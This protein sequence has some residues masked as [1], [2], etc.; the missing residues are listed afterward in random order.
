MNPAKNGNAKNNIMRGPQGEQGPPGPRG[1]PGQRG[2]PG[3]PGD[4]GSPGTGV[5][6]LGT[7]PLV[8]GKTYNPGDLI[9]VPETGIV[10]ICIQQNTNGP[11]GKL[12]SEAAKPYWQLYSRGGVN[13]ASVNFVG[14]YSPDVSYNYYDTVNDTSGHYFLSIWNKENDA[15]LGYNIRQPLPKY[16]ISGNYSLVDNFGN[17]ILDAANKLQPSLYWKFYTRDGYTTNFTGEYSLTKPYSYYDLAT[18]TDASGRKTTY[19]SMVKGSKSNTGNDP[20]TMG[21]NY[22]TIYSQDGQNGTSIQYKGIWSINTVYS[23]NDV[24]KDTSDNSYISNK[25]NNKGN[26]LPSFNATSYVFDVSN[27]YWDLLTKAGSTFNQRGKWYSDVC[28]NLYDV[29]SDNSGSTFISKWDNVIGDVNRGKPLPTY[30]YATNTYADTKYWHFLV[31]NGYSITST[32]YWSP[33]REYFEGNLAK[34]IGDNSINIVY[35]SIWKPGSGIKNL[36]RHP[37]TD[38]SAS[39]FWSEYSRDGQNGANGLGYKNRGTWSPDLSY[40]VQDVIYYN[41]STYSCA[42]GNINKVPPENS[43]YWYTFFDGFHSRGDWSNNNLLG[44][45]CYNTFDTVTFRNTQFTCASFNK[46]KTTPNSQ[47]NPGYDTTYWK[48]YIQGTYY[49][50][51]WISGG[52]YYYNDIT[53]FKGTSYQCASGITSSQDPP[54]LGS[55][56]WNSTTQGFHNKGTWDPSTV[57]HINDVVSWKNSIYTCASNN[58]S[59]IAIMPSST[60]TVPKFWTVFSE[61]YN[62]RGFWNNGNTW[63]TPTTGPTGISYDLF[64][65][66]LFHNTQFT[67]ASY[68]NSNDPKTTPNPGFHT[69][70]WEVYIPNV[71]YINAEWSPNTRYYFNDSITYK[72]TSYLCIS[73]TPISNNGSPDVSS[74]YWF[75]TTQGVQFKGAWASNNYYG[76]QDMVTVN[77]SFYTCISGNT[78]TP[79]NKPPNTT[80]WYQLIASNN[81][82]GDWSANS[83]TTDFS[84]SVYD[85]VTFRNTQFV[86]VSANTV[87]NTNYSQVQPNPGYDTSYWKRYINATYYAGQWTSGKTYYYN[88]IAVFKGSSYQCVSGNTSSLNPLEAGSTYWTST[89]A[90]FHNRGQWNA[91]VTYYLNDVVSHKNS[92]YCCASSNILNIEPNSAV[93]VPDYWTVFSEGYNDRRSWNNGNWTVPINY[94]T[95]ISYDLF[96]QVLFRNTKF[97]CVTPHTTG[98]DITVP[99][100]GFDTDYW[101]L[102]IAG[103]YYI[104]APWSASTRYYFKDVIT[105]N[106]SRYSCISGTP[107]GAIINGSPDVSSNYWFK[108]SQG[109][110]LRGTWASNNYYGVQDMVTVNNSFYS[111]ISGNTATTS[112]KP[113]NST[114]WTPLSISTNIRGDWSANNVKVDVSYSAYDQVTFRNTQFLCISANTVTNN[115]YSQVQPNPGYDTPYWRIYGNRGTYYAGQ[116]ASGG[117]YYYNDIAV[118]RSTSYQC[119]SGITSHKDPPTLGTSYWES[120]IQ[121][122]ENKGEWKS[123]EVYHINDVVSYKN[124]VY[125][126]ASNNVSGQAT[127]PSSTLTVPDY[128]TVFSEGYYNRG[129]WNDGSWSLPVSRPGVS[130][131]LFDLVTFRGSQFTCISYNNSFNTATVPN[132]GFNTLYWDV[133]NGQKTYNVPGNWTQGSRYYYNDIVTNADSRFPLGKWQCISGNYS[134][135]ITLS[136]NTYWTATGTQGVDGQDGINSKGTFLKGVKYNEKDIVQFHGSTFEC[137]S[138]ITQS[139]DYSYNKTVYPSNDLSN[140]QP[141]PGLNTPYWK[142]TILSSSYFVGTWTASGTYYQNDVVSLNQYNPYTFTCISFNSGYYPPLVNSSAYWSKYETNGNPSATSHEWTTGISYEI[143]HQVTFH[144]ATFQC[145]SNITQSIPY[146]KNGSISPNADTLNNQPIPGINT[147]YWVNISKAISYSAGTWSSNTTYYENDVVSLGPNSQYTFTCL[148]FNTG[149]YPPSPLLNP[150]TTN[151][152]QPTPL[153]KA[154]STWSPISNYTYSDRYYTY[155]DVVVLPSTIYSNIGVTFQCISNITQIVPY[156]GTNISTTTQPIPGPQYFNTSFWNVLPATAPSTPIFSASG[157]IWNKDVIYYYYDKV[158]LGPNNPT[159]YRCETSNKG[160]YPPTASASYWTIINSPSIPVRPW[161]AG[162]SF[163]FGSLTTFNGNTFQCISNITQSQSIAYNPQ[164][165]PTDSRNTQPIPGVDTLY[166]NYSKSPAIKASSPN[167]MSG[168]YSPTQTYYYNDLVTLGPYS[169]STYVCASLNSYN[170]S[171][172]P[173][174]NIGTYWNSPTVIQGPTRTWA[175]GISYQ[176]YDYVSFH[177]TVFTCLSYISQSANYSNYSA[178]IPPELDTLN[179]QPIPGPN[180]YKTPYWKVQSSTT[181]PTGINWTAGGN[182]YYNDIVTNTLPTYSLGSWLCISGNY[183]NS[184]ITLN[185]NV[186][187]KGTGTNGTNGTNGSEGDNGLNGLILIDFTKDFNY[188]PYIDIN[189]QLNLSNMTLSDLIVNDSGSVQLIV[190]NN[191]APNNNYGQLLNSSSILYSIDYGVNWNIFAIF[192]PVILTSIRV[193]SSQKYQ[194]VIGFENMDGTQSP[195]GNKIVL[196]TSNNYGASW[197]NNIKYKDRTVYNYIKNVQKLPPISEYVGIGLSYVTTVDASINQ[198]IIYLNNT[199]N[200]VPKM[201]IFGNGISNIV[202][203][204]NSTL[205]YITVYNNITQVIPSG[206]ILLFNPIQTNSNITN[207]PKTIFVNSV[208]KLCCYMG[209]TGSNIPSN[210]YI[211]SIDDL[212]NYITINNK[213]LGNI[214]FSSVIP[215]DVNLPMLT[216]SKGVTKNVVPPSS[217]VN[218]KCTSFVS[219]PTTTYISN[220]NGTTTTITPPLNI[221]TLTNYEKNIY[222]VNPGT[223]IYIAGYTFTICMVDY[224]ANTIAVLPLYSHFDSTNVPITTSLGNINVLNVFTTNYSIATS[225]G[226]TILTNNTDNGGNLLPYAYIDKNTIHPK[227]YTGSPQTLVA[228][229]INDGSFNTLKILNSTN[230][231]TTQPLQQYSNLIIPLTDIGSISIGMYV[232]S[233]NNITIQPDNNGTTYPLI[234]TGIGYFSGTATLV[235]GALSGSNQLVMNKI[236]IFNSNDTTTGINSFLNYFYTTNSFIPYLN[237]MIVS[238]NSTINF[239]DNTYITSITYNNSLSNF[240][241]VTITISQPIQNDLPSN[242]T[243]SFM[244]NFITC[245]NNGTNLTP[246]TNPIPPDI[247]FS[248]SYNKTFTSSNNSLIS[249]NITITDLDNI[250]I[251]MNVE[252]TNIPQ[253]SYITNISSS[254]FSGVSYYD[255]SNNISSDIINYTALSPIHNSVFSINTLNGITLGTCVYSSTSD[256]A[257]SLTTSNYF[258]VA[259]NPIVSYPLVKDSLINTNKLYFS[260]VD[261]SFIIPN[262]TKIIHENISSGTVVKQISYINGLYCITINSSIISSISNLTYIS[263]QVNLLT[264]VDKN[265]TYTYDTNGCPTNTVSDSKWGNSGN[266][267]TFI[268]SNS[269]NT[270]TISQNSSIPSYLPPFTRLDYTNTNVWYGSMLTLSSTQNLYTNMLAV[271]ENIAD[272][273]CILN[274]LNNTVSLSKPVMN[275]LPIGSVIKFYPVSK[276]TYTQSRFTQAIMLTSSPNGE[277]STGDIIFGTGSGIRPNTFVM[278]NGIETIQNATEYPINISVVNGFSG[279]ANKTL[280]YKLLK[281]TT[282]MQTDFGNTL[283]LNITTSIDKD[284]NKITVVFPGMT[285][286]GTNIPYNTKILSVNTINNTIVISNNINQPVPLNTALDIYFEYTTTSNVFSGTTM[287]MPQGQSVFGLSTGMTLAGSGM[288]PNINIVNI[289]TSN[290]WITLSDIINYDSYVPDLWPFGQVFP[291]IEGPDMDRAGGNPTGNLLNPGGYHS[292]PWNIVHIYSYLIYNTV[293]ILANTSYVIVNNLNGIKEGMT[294]VLLYDTGINTGKI[295]DKSGGP[296][297]FGSFTNYFPSNITVTNISYTNN[298]IYLSSPI[299]FPSNYTNSSIN[300]FL[301]F[302]TP[303]IKTIASISA[304]NL[305]T[306]CLNTTSNLMIGMQITSSSNTTFSGIISNI[307]FTTNIITLQT[308]L[309]GKIDVG[310]ILYSSTNK[311]SI[312]DNKLYS[313]NTY[314]T[315][316]TSI[317]TDISVIPINSI[318]NLRTGMIVSGSNIPQ[319][320]VVTSIN[321]SSTSSS[322]QITNLIHTLP[323]STYL[324]FTLN[325]I[326]ISQNI[327]SIISAGTSLQFLNTTTT[328]PVIYDDGNQTLGDISNNVYSI[329]MSSDG[330]FQTFVSGY[331]DASISTVYPGVL[332]YCSSGNTQSPYP[333]WNNISISPA[334]AFNKVA[335]SSNGQYQTAVGYNNNGTIFVS[336][337]YGSTWTPIQLITSNTLAYVN[338]RFINATSFTNTNF[339]DVT[340]NSTGKYQYI[341]GY[342]KSNSLGGFTINNSNYNGIIFSSN[343]FGS[344][345]SWSQAP[346]NTIDTNLF[347]LATGNTNNKSTIINLSSINFSSISSNSTGNYIMTSGNQNNSTT[348]IFYSVDYGL[349]WFLK[350]TNNL[351]LITSQITINGDGSKQTIIGECDPTSTVIQPLFYSVIPTVIDTLSTNNPIIAPVTYNYTSSY[352]NN[353]SITPSPDYIGGSIQSTWINN[354]AYLCCNNLPCSYPYNSINTT[355]FGNLTSFNSSLLNTNP[356][357]IIPYQVNSTYYTYNT[358]TR[359][360][361]TTEVIYDS[362]LIVTNGINYYFN[363]VQTIVSNVTITNPGVYMAIAYCDIVQPLYQKYSYYPDSLALGITLSNVDD[364]NTTNVLASTYNGNLYLSNFIGTSSNCTVP[365]YFYSSKVGI[366]GNNFLSISPNNAFSR[367]GTSNRLNLTELITI[368]NVDIGNNNNVVNLVACSPSII[369]CVYDNINAA[370]N[371]NTIPQTSSLLLLSGQITLVRI[372]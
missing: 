134:A 228:Y 305:K 144:N 1:L 120:N 304:D 44:D 362:S 53:I 360:A 135:Q 312:S 148:S 126:C 85:Q 210:S 254:S 13:G 263:F 129:L 91:T 311:V 181:Y 160:L 56:Y 307:N 38:P 351:S 348:N 297:N 322:I 292:G 306:F 336:S 115:N 349:T 317:I 51:Q 279:Y 247:L 116:W 354:S 208:N 162:L 183:G 82:R 288:V 239:L 285:V 289:D 165:S 84:Y 272:N 45:I 16:D 326:T 212:N 23:A 149:I 249:N 42:S 170:S 339:V 121:G 236:T 30:N 275:Y 215:I 299:T 146:S 216:F 117:T 189:D 234:I 90:G 17:F 187:W 98:E 303:Q 286:N 225:S 103:E 329:A 37:V 8:S 27:E 324:S 152:W 368:S 50:G 188:K 69:D 201:S 244:Y 356:A 140:N 270:S 359:V 29:V 195:I 293:P 358:S 96:D 28:Y 278:P 346:V 204:V 245:P 259:I 221:Y 222:G 334:T 273:T 250:Y 191:I 341:V 151:Y 269:L 353:L 255:V 19:L 20:L 147:K 257:N 243:I 48:R 318:I 213:L 92:I 331:I 11:F 315:T 366:T 150:V 164:Y 335:M 367:N 206:T 371:T 155:G 124:S 287:P 68:N 131:E 313:S 55:T 284:G 174:T 308:A 319:G 67:C 142:N 157:S 63:R 240:T 369:G 282:L 119:V 330:I 298:K 365:N 364:A 105:Y 217:S 137:L 178:I 34:I 57:Y 241:N 186:Y 248:L 357:G 52:T 251:G 40:S 192:N 33:S 143:G 97:T 35:N 194:T 197:Y 258:V 171:Q 176:L 122:F 196:L 83:V 283:Y 193:S 177:N 260:Y 207:N 264:V 267:L 26:K 36:N 5:Q 76:I 61:G 226:K 238:D 128:W 158:V 94:A 345:G 32:G 132:P 79:S 325:T 22:W 295:N 80:Y 123:T 185:N 347:S 93:T 363:N 41:N 77:N 227:V 316:N 49:A 7:F 332:Y 294:V 74:N 337:N 168:Y 237:G 39:S 214:S 342:W 246:I 223:I 46:S 72:G 166:W 110:Q 220:Y 87:N 104:N 73:G 58:I 290:N 180:G 302:Y 321:Y 266:I 182:Y 280:F 145:V 274:I 344:I 60:L 333:L 78:A 211:T 276:H 9:S 219:P 340:M 99:N 125:N 136:N 47:P 100:P 291:V 59:G 163:E 232:T 268:F 156:T 231:L 66:V 139:L 262:V 21:I 199:Y 108:S 175:V 65:Q 112:N 253:N 372:A 24:V 309:P 141:I 256:Y 224:V 205:N 161:S 18:T 81:V 209:I 138:N 203:S 202:N 10:Y 271:N 350:P 179:N 64:D 6:F 12:D 86:C 14:L 352:S 70:Y 190:G 114:Y 159:E 281:I 261:A 101:D 4:A 370:L 133:V 154:S 242:S 54:T 88:D 3:L 102:D 118:F 301:V 173:P 184:S 328:N 229:D 310:T 252:G 233:R 314:Y 355:W 71:Y 167:I 200:I 172:Y 75:K 198:Q 277:W 31:A 111:C 265:K 130:Y 25:D 62:N 361:N 2:P 109:T 327:T 127:A 323:P 153:P 218:Y 15:K 43:Y 107:I 235:S 106:G 89:T 169:P 296:S 338:K 230:L 113:P 343:Y 95:T 320:S 300:G